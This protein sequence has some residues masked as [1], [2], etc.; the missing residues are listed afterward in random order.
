MSSTTE[1]GN[2][3][4]LATLSEQE[5][6]AI[7]GEAPSEDEIASLKAI[8]GDSDDSDDG[9]E[10][11]AAPDV[12]VAEAREPEVEVE[13]EPAPVP[14]A[15]DAKVPAYIATLPDDFETRKEALE[16]KSGD[17]WSRFEAGDIDRTTLQAELR[18]ID[19]ERAAL[20]RIETK[21]ELSRE[22]NEQA[23]QAAWQNQVNS[24]MTETAAAGV[25][26]RTDKA[27]G[28][29]LDYFVKALAGNDA[30]ADKSMGWFLQE[31]HKRVQALYGEAPPAGLTPK[32]TVAQA[33]A[34][35]TPDVT[36]AGRNLAQVPGS[37]GPG[38]IGGEFVHLDTLDGPAMEAAIARMSPAQREKFLQGA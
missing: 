30:N 2:A 9:V 25:D 24:F 7:M 29:D 13:A 26:Y 8:A 21:A 34:R 23:N 12:E 3:D 22:M 27:R 18:G 17:A 15:V 5:R 28:T 36:A 1:F 38:D 6:E 31:A 35:R 37:G 11:Q 20:E 10:D 19:T 4:T 33:V 14:A 32:P 16:E